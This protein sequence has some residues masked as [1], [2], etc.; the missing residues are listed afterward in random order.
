MKKGIEATYLALKYP[1]YRTWR[2]L[3]KALANNGRWPCGTPIRLSDPEM[4][5]RMDEI[6]ENIKNDPAYARALLDGN[7]K[8]DKK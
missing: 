5:P 8:Y 7:T 2:D 1:D 6:K 4:K 3:N